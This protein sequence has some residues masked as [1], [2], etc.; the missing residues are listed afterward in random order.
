MSMVMSVWSTWLLLSAASQAQTPG[1]KASAPAQSKET[2]WQWVLRF[3]GVS[4][5]PSTLKGAD[6]EPAAGQVWTADLRS[7]AVR[8]IT[9]EDGYRSPVFYPNGADILALQDTDVVRIS[10]GG[11]PTAKLHHVA[12]ITKLVGFSLDDPDEVLILRED[13]E[14]HPSVARL[15]LKTGAVALLP[16]DPQS[17]RDRQVLE[18]LQ[19]WQRT[20]GATTVYV[21]RES[22]ETLSGMVERT[23]VFV[24]SAG[25]DPVNVS[26]CDTTNCGQPS[27]SPDGTRV[28][29]IK[30]G[31]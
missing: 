31:L 12:G 14:G 15:S 20:Y 23:N 27:L 10:A 28:L 5:N 25:K 24:K 16:Y 26:R 8:K 2:F 22:K 17:S 11:N 7:D 9:P 6:D 19:G 18:D 21:K 29:F 4:A 1:K 30:A 3:S 13:D